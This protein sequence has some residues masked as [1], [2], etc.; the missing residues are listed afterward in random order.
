MAINVSIVGG[1]GYA[2]GELVRLL[3]SH[4]EVNINQIT[5]E[6]NKGKFI[7]LLHPNLRKICNL[8]FSSINDL[9][10]CDVLFLTLPHGMTKNRLTEFSNLAD[11]I[12]DLSQDFRLSDK[13]VYGIAELHRG[14]LK[15]ANFIACA[16]CNATATILGLYPF[17][18]EKL[19]RENQTTV[20]AKISSSAS[21]N[22]ANLGTH[23]PERSGVVRSY[24]PTGHRHI[25]EIK[26]ELNTNNVHFSATSI[27]MVRGILITAQLFPQNKLSD[28]DIWKLYRKYYNDEP[29]I[30]IIKE[31]KGVYRYPEPK[32]LRGTNYCDIGFEVDEESGR[33]V[34][35]SAIDNLVK[36]AAGQ[37][38]QAF[39][40]RFNFPE[41]TG[42]E[43]NGLHPC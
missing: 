15:T 26:Q 3:I 36:G 42:L 38:V 39:N 31:K 22:K 20:E 40:I 10:K 21:G 35:M 12:I 28:K 14:E 19:I 6:S 30:R 32:L 7:S 25:Q 33:I 5:S 43:F 9:K 27:E 8:K 41:I 24:M 11:I 13:F 29:F 23:H 17:Y 18:K 2:G 16:G 1:S 4:P 37:A 34:I